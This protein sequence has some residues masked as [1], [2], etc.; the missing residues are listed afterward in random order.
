MRPLHLAG[1]TSKHQVQ[2]AHKLHGL[3]ALCYYKKVFI[4][5]V[6]SVVFYHSVLRMLRQA[7][8]KP[9]HIVLEARQNVKGTLRLLCISV[10]KKHTT[11]HNDRVY[12]L[13]FT[14]DIT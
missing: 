9:R 4:N 11:F 7:M 12:Y 2:T 5:V 8:A 10:K 1:H 13:K 6:Y 14:D 3:S